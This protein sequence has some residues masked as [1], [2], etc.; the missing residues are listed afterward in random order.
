MR[1]LVLSTH[2]TL[3]GFA[4]GPDGELDWH[5]SHWND[6]MEEAVAEQLSTVDT[7]LVGRVT[8]EVMA[9]YWPAAAADPE[10]RRKDIQFAEWMNRVA[11]IVFSR[12]LLPF[13][14]EAIH[15]NNTRL[16]SGRIV[17]QVE[18]LKKERGKDMIVWGGVSII[19]T[20]IG[21][22]IVDEYNIWI[23]PVILGEGKPL[24]IDPGVLEL[25]LIRTKTFR[26][27]VTLVC[28]RPKKQEQAGNAKTFAPGNY[29]CNYATDRI[30]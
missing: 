20:F 4:S 12:R 1:K 11:K 22:G 9:D 21:L 3:D 19:Q 13:D 29:H 2:V 17:E 26:S 15:W 24:F 10:G 27:G 18:A 8:Y 30:K 14:V 23:A 16:I 7:I 25:E 6:E 28:Y 5:F